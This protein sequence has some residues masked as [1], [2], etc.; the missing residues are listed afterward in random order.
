MPVKFLDD[1]AFVK[2]YQGDDPKITKRDRA[3]AARS[4]ASCAAFGLIEGDVDLIESYA[5][6]RC[7]R[8]RRLLRPGEAG[9]RRAG[10]RP[11]RR[12]GP[13]TLVHEL[14]H[15]LQDQHFDLTEARPRGRDLRRGLRPHRARRGRRDE[16]RGRLLFSLS[17]AE[18][19]AYFARRPTTTVDAAPAATDDIPPVLDLFV[20]RPV[21]LRLALPRG[22]A[23]VGGMK[24]VEPS[25]RDAADVGGAD[26]RPGGGDGGAARRGG[27]PPRSSTADE[28]RHG[29]VDDFGALEPVPRARGAPRSRGRV[30][31]GR[32]M[33]RRSLRRLREARERRGVRPRRDPG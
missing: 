28:K 13:V 4:P 1:A 30:D 23:R 31:R 24:R 29:D 3:E 14:T 12:R 22:P 2:A 27:S 5:R 32:G 17:D 7:D 10:D 21:H 25:V 11:R 33:G 18:Q 20:G 19:D 16:R 8:H 15:A 26:H 9:A 6:P